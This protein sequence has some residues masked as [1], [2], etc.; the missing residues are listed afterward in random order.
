MN[1]KHVGVLALLVTLLGVVGGVGAAT[2]TTRPLSFVTPSGNITCLVTPAA[3]EVACALSQKSWQVP[4]G[5]RHWCGHTALE[6]VT[7]RRG[8]VATFL[9]ATDVLVPHPDE[10]LA[11]GH[12][13]SAGGFTCW[14][15]RTGVTCGDRESHRFFV[16]RAAYRLS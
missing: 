5:A 15:R 1:A 12:T 8:H 9:C 2:A 7:M 14:S 4:G 11:Y 3:H 16:S 13:L 6:G 10:V